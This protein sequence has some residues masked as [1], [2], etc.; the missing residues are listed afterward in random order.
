MKP[1]DVATADRIPVSDF[2]GL[3][4]PPANWPV[5]QV[6]PK[7]DHQGTL[8]ETPD[9]ALTDPVLGPRPGRAMFTA[10]HPDVFAIKSFL[11]TLE[12]TADAP[13]DLLAMPGVAVLSEHCQAVAV[14]DGLKRGLVRE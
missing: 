3:P 4:T 7:P 9:S 11:D 14:I 12:N 13:S 1:F 2:V 5:T 6:E 8:T 10:S